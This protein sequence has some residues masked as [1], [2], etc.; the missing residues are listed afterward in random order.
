MQKISGLEVDLNILDPKDYNELIEILQKKVEK[1]KILK[2]VVD[3]NSESFTQ[4][5]NYWINKGIDIKNIELKDLFATR[6][7]DITEK[8]IFYC[9]DLDYLEYE[10]LN[11]EAK[12]LP[13]SL[14]VIFG[15]FV[16]EGTNI[17]FVNLEFVGGSGDISYCKN[18]RTTNIGKVGMFLVFDE[19]HQL[20]TTNIGDVGRFLDFRFCSNLEEIITGDVAEFLRFFSCDCTKVGAVNIGDVKGEINFQA[21]SGFNLE[22]VFSSK[23]KLAKIKVGG[24]LSIKSSDLEIYSDEQLLEK[25]EVDPDKIVRN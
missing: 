7:E 4:I 10:T 2:I 1:L 19:C 5:E 8:T 22:N 15:S 24:D 17:E 14:K 20:Q 12:S 3:L 18:L 9:G 25:F 6:V 11:P 13:D 21:N 16:A 23:S